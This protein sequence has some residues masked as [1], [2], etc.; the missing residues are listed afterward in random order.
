MKRIYLDQNIWVELSRARIGSPGAR[1]GFSDAYHLARRAVAH[2][3]ASFVL[4]QT[5]MY[6]TQKRQ[7]W[8]KR[9][10]IVETMIELSKIHAI[11]HV[12]EVVPLEADFAIQ[13][14][15]GFKSSQINVFGSGIQSLLS[16]SVVVQPIPQSFDLRELGYRES[17]IEIAGSGD[18][19]RLWDALLLAGPPPGMTSSHILAALQG[20]DT[21]FAID[22]A[23]V[24]AA[25]K[26]L[27]VKGSQLEEAL[28][29][30]RFNGSSQHRLVEPIV[31]G[32]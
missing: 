25:I 32:R 30:P 15:G 6:E 4:S 11:R 27:G 18:P 22:Q 2:G 20:V 31:D 13:S 23:R 8:D 28:T 12:T 3:L 16:K 29:Q 24:A 10:D 21:A 19:S 7:Q 17:F 9:L 14:L 5:H 1:H 26:A